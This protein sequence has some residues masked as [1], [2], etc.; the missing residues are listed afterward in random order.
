MVP[1]EPERNCYI[2]KLCRMNSFVHEV[3]HEEKN[4]AVKLVVIPRRQEM[5][6]NKWLNDPLR[7]QRSA[8][9]KWGVSS[10]MWQQSNRFGSFLGSYCQHEFKECPRRRCHHRHHYYQDFTL[11]LRRVRDGGDY[12][13]Q[14]WSLDDRKASLH[15]CSI[16][17]LLSVN[18]G[19]WRGSYPLV[20]L[21]ANPKSN[22]KLFLE[23][24]KPE[25]VCQSR[26]CS[27][28]H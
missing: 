4:K 17:L 25:P 1:L 14:V 24:R 7:R 22:C 26:L 19:L 8:K 9:G 2:I 5:W 20:D 11:F 15:V 6:N 23:L 27:W 28:G 13:V 16:W 10:W 21:H 12:F 18:L 3:S